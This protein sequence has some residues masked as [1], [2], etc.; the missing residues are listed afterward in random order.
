[1]LQGYVILYA[2]D[3]GL[4][5]FLSAGVCQAKIRP[6][7]SWNLQIIVPIE[8]VNYKIED[9]DDGNMKNLVHVDIQRAKTK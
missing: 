4:Q 7:G 8:A 2:A 9:T 5:E 3:G 6:E 1:M